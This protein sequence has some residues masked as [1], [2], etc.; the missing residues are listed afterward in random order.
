MNL[1][2]FDGILLFYL[3]NSIDLFSNNYIK[4]KNL[5]ENTNNLKYY[6]IFYLNKKY[7]L[8]AF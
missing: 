5:F 2:V 6:D 3:E 4:Y 1:T 7:L 8:I